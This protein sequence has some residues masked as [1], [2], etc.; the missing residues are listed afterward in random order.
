[1]IHG[2]YTSLSSLSLSDQSLLLELMVRP[3]SPFI[4]INLSWIQACFATHQLFNPSSIPDLQF[5][6]SLLIPHSATC[7]S[8]TSTSMN[9][10]SRFAM[11]SA[12]TSK[13]ITH[14]MACHDVVDTGL[15]ALTTLL[16]TTFAL[17]QAAIQAA[18]SPSQIA[19]LNTPVGMRGL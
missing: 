2:K 13:T 16:V 6:P 14:A 15:A 19:T 4:F 18:C 3:E 10:G 12:T 7:A 9:P 17:L 1:L 11:A 5:D 8:P